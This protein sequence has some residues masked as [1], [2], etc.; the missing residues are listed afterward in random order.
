[1]SEITSG[2]LSHGEGRLVEVQLLSH[3]YRRQQEQQQYGSY[4]IFHKPNAG[5]S[6][7]L[8]KFS[9]PRAR[10]LYSMMYK[11]SL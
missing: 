1:M 3:S 11:H 4:R 6:F 2:Y 5:L 9:L 7:S 10:Q 8:I